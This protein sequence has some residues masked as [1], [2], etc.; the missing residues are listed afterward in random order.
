[1]KK[2]NEVWTHVNLDEVNKREY[3]LDNGIITCWVYQIYVGNQWCGQQ[4][5][6]HNNMKLP[7]FDYSFYRA[8][9]AEVFKDELVRKKYWETGDL[10]CGDAYNESATIPFTDVEWRVK[11]EFYYK[12]GRKYNYV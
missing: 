9:I 12:S 3:K 2:N 10:F 4:K 6:Y 7:G 1:M 8:N 5:V 11:P